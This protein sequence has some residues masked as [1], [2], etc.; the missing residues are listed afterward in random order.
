MKLLFCTDFHLGLTRVEHTTSE[1]AERLQQ[2]IF[3]R[4]MQV[5]AEDGKF[6]TV[7]NGGDLFH[8]HSNP[9]SIVLQGIEVASHCDYILAGNHDVI[10]IKGSVSSLDVVAASKTGVLKNPDPSTP[11]VS[12][13]LLDPCALDGSGTYLYAVPHCFTQEIFEHSIRAAAERAGRAIG[14]KILL[15]HCNVG[16]G[17]GHL[18]SDSTTLWLTEELQELVR[19]HFGLIMVGHEHDPRVIGSLTDAR[20]AIVV[21]GNLFPVSFGEISDRFV[22]EVDSESL[23][24]NPI[25]I[26]DAV[27]AWAVIGAQDLIDC[28]GAWPLDGAQFID[29]EGEIAQEDYGKL[30]R[31]LGKLRKNNPQALMVRN[32]ATVPRPEGAQGQDDVMGMESL[33]ERVGAEAIKAG[34]EVEYN[35]LRKEVDHG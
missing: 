6:R 20:G 28:D 29:I 15:L 1:S 26:F 31:A 10:N 9:E 19:D 30:G 2:E 8:K 34:Y 3:S 7:I 13:V 5:V 33:I 32:G 27:E 14:Y 21:M 24:V 22:Y 4:A 11:M 17:F 25:K 16:T 12:V 23:E 35:E 18:E